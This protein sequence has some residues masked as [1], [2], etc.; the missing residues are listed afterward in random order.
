MFIPRSLSAGD[1]FQDVICFGGPDEGLG[2]LIVA[3]DV[4]SDGYDELFEV[5][6]GAAPDSVFGQV[7][8]EALD[9]VE[10]RGRSG[11]E[12][13]M[14]SLMASHPALHPF[15]FVR[16]VVVADDVDLLFT[17]HSL[18]DRDRNFSHS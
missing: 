9:H 8:E 18:V 16:R 4:I 13:H 6:E 5:L 11:R 7:A 15:M 12:V 17:C 1:L 2:I 10:P 14:E 3:V